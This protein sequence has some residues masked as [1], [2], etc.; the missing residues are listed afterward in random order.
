MNVPL[1][2]LS[3]Y[4]KLPKSETDLTD[5][6]TMIGHMLDKRAVVNG[7]VVIDLELRGNRSDLFGMIGI[8]REISAAWNVPLKLPRTKLLPKVSKNSLVTVEATDLVE[9][10]T[11]FTLSVKVGPS[12]SWLVKHLA[13][14]GTPSINNVVDITNFVMLETGEPMHAYD[15]DKLSGKKLIIRRAKQGET[16]TTLQ[17]STLKFTK[18]DLVIAD[19]KRPQG[20]A[21]IGSLTS[22]V[23]ETTKEILLEAAVYNQANVRRTA[24]RLGVRTE[25]GN[26]H[27]KLLDPNQV[28]PALERAYELL[29][30]LADAKSTGTVADVYVKKRSSIAI[31]IQLSDIKRLCGVTVTSTAVSDYLK[32]LGFVI[33]KKKQDIW[34]VVAP[35]YRTD[36]DQSADVVEEIVRLF[37][38]E[39]IPTHTLSG[40]LPEPNTYPMV[41]LI[42]NT[43][44][45]LVSLAQNEVITSPIIDNSLVSLYA[46]NGTF[47][48]PVTLVNAPDAAIATMR[49]SL[50][51]N[52]VEYAK[53]S[54]GFRQRRIAIFEVG[55]IYAKDKKLAYKETEMLGLI[56]HGHI[57]TAS[58][59]KSPRPLTVYDLKGVIEGLCADLGATI[60]ITQIASHPSMDSSIQATVSVGDLRIGTFGKIHKEIAIEVGIPEETFVAELSLSA[61][62]TIQRSMPQPYVIAPAYPP[63]IEDLTVV[64]TPETRIGEVI[65]CI[66]SCDTRIQKVELVDVYENNRSL[67]VTYIDAQKTLSTDEVKPIHDRILTILK[68]KFGISLLTT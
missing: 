17:G 53:R 13:L 21:I 67:R 51:P 55:K 44:D 9:R 54:L 45:I 64:V 27:E 43:R 5:K 63:L 37:G 50:L 23:T 25:A 68:D 65:A 33:T 57:D 41:T 35:T 47:T 19:E 20:T 39:K 40:Q 32:R 24:R 2:W 61:L 26:R 18:E 49:P 8:A 30:E 15:L 31:D 14:Y 48:S 38:Y 22:G 42:E 1:C 46:R 28:V 6:L 3:Q 16:M 10:F 58:W 62:S 34:T 29:I 12:P 60:T 66:Q 36:I 11:G 7:D 56:M 52:L 4:V 59:N